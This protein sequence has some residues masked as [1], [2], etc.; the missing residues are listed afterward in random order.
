MT[1]VPLTEASALLETRDL[2]KHFG[3]IP[4]TDSLNLSVSENTVHALIGP[5]GAGKSTTVAQICGTLR[6]DFGQVLFRG[7]D[8]TALPVHRRTALGL[9]R[10]FQITSLFPEFSARENVALALIGRE[11]KTWSLQR[12]VKAD[13]DL[14]D[15]AEA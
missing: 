10:S 1:A 15:R 2:T 6:P 13:N 11:G 4:A 12:P 9:G 5:N 3:G 8:I 14:Q 7:Q